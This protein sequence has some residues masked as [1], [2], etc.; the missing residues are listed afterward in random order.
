MFIRSRRDIDSRRSRRYPLAFISIIFPVFLISGLGYLLGRLRGMET[1]TLVDIV[2]FL[3]VPA[4]IFSRLVNNP[5]T[6]VQ[7]GQISIYALALCALMYLIGAVFARAMRLPRLDRYALLLSVVTMNMAN[8]GLPVV[9]FAV[10]PDAVSYAVVLVLAVNIVQVTVGVYLAAAGRLS[11]KQ[12][13]MSIFRLPLI[14]AF[15]AA[16]VVLGFGIEVPDP[17]MRPMVMLG[18]A[19]IPAGLVVL[20]V[21]LTRV[22]LGNAWKNVGVI[23]VTRLVISPL[24]GLGLV[25]LLGITGDMRL[26]LVIE[27]G[28]PTA[29]NAGLLAIEFDTKPEFVA[30]AI[31]V[32]TLASAVTLSALITLLGAG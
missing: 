11:P 24:V 29:I 5:V 30:G 28:M 21:Q 2:L 32:T 12:A 23:T 25:F 7:A 9:E 27:A 4:L 19:A 1:K 26:T 8:Y 16:F 14:Y 3:L 10:G 6:L 18:D 22:H 17:I 31:L 13:I 20:G 15:V